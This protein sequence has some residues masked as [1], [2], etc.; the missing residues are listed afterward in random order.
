MADFVPLDAPPRLTV[1]D[2]GSEQCPQGQLPGALQFKPGE[3]QNALNPLQYVPVVGMIYRQATGETI[4][5]P[6]QILG[7]V[8]TGAMFGGPIGVLGSVLM[9]VVLELARLGPDTSRPPVPE[10]MDVTGS[11][12]PIRAVSPGDKRPDGSYLTLATT[13]PDFLGGPN[14]IG[15]DGKPVRKAIAAY[16]AG[17]AM[18]FG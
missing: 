11:E 4:A 3:M 7:S 1:F 13:L 2:T 12:A 18:G 14:A 8:A 5:P 15:D 9:N 6:V 16:E 17:T 10:G